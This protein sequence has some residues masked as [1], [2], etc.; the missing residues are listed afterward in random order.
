MLLKKRVVLAA[1][2]SAELVADIGELG[3]SLVDIA[4]VNVGAR[5]DAVDDLALVFE[6]HSLDELK[7]S[8]VLDL[9]TEFCE[10]TFRREACS[11]IGHERTGEARGDGVEARDGGVLHLFFSF[12][13][14]LLFSLRG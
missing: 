10:V 8:W 13:V 5:V 3:A 11:E 7:L 2:A 9:S 14:G 4:H 6:Q 12:V 1:E